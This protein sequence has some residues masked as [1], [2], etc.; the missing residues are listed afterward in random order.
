MKQKVLKTLHST[1]ENYLDGK[2][3]QE[4][5]DF[6]KSLQERYQGKEI[7]VRWEQERWSEDYELVLYERRDETDEE[8]KIRIKK[9]KRQ[10]EIQLEYKRLQLEKLKKEL[11][12]Q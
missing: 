12:E 10:Q 8:E 6:L 11:G 3:L 7:V 5:I 1:I 4:S 9:E 2:T